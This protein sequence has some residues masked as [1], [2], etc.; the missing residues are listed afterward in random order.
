MLDMN[1]KKYIAVST[2]GE[3]LKKYR[4]EK[5]LKST[6]RFFCDKETIIEINCENQFM[7]KDIIKTTKKNCSEIKIIEIGE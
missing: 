4:I 5:K 3:S 2:L 1:S 6:H 7:I